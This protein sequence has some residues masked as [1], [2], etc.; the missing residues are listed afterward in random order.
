M[1]DY[2]LLLGLTQLAFWGSIYFFFC[3]LNMAESLHST[4]IHVL[5]N[6]LMSI[7]CWCQDKRNMNFLSFFSVFI[8]CSISMSFIFFGFCI[9]YFDFCIFLFLNFCIFVLLQ[10]FSSFSYRFHLTLAKALKFSKIQSKGP[11]YTM[12]DVLSI[13]FFA[14]V[15]FKTFPRRN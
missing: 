7:N 8:I 2:F 4:F 11:R 13:C 12:P 1:E 3:W 14:Q 6:L 10:F 9:F 15:I 5:S